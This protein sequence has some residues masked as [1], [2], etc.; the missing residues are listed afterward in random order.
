MIRMRSRDQRIYCLGF[1]PDGRKLAAAGAGRTV[2]VWD[3]A[4]IA[5]KPRTL[6][7]PVAF[8]G[9]HAIHLL[10]D[11]RILAANRWSVVASDADHTRLTRTFEGTRDRTVTALAV[12]P[13]R[14][15][16]FVGGF[17][18]ECWSLDGE[19]ALQWVA[20]G[21]TRGTY[22]AALAVSADGQTLAVNGPTGQTG[23]HGVHLR[24]TA[25]GGATRVF[26]PLQTARILTLTPDGTNLVGISGFSVV[27]W[28]AE[29][30]KALNRP[31]AGTEG[32]HFDAVAVHPSG[33]F[34]AA[35]GKS[36]KVHL[37]ET[38]TGRHSQS[39]EWNVGRV[40][41]LAFSP[42]GLTGVVGGHTGVVVWDVDA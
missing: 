19:P 18:L 38:D 39:H 42:D 4:D 1:S 40:Y 31:K 27:V 8:Y 14:S 16:A 13:D 41:A 9:Y 22:F 36:G 28:D 35:G 37:F 5:A 17:G 25:V 32:R 23:L 20:P 30:G 12:S 11:Y 3:L 10:P 24:A 26:D 6:V 34:L 33:R 7:G 21:G 15:R 29:T 2:Y